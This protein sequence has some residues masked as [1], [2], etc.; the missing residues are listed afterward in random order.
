MNPSVESDCSGISLGTHYC[1]STD[2]VGLNDPAIDEG[3][4]STSTLSMSVPTN[5]ATP[6]PIQVYSL[7]LHNSPLDSDY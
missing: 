1:I 5:S 3:D 4:A 7:L 6:L 2:K